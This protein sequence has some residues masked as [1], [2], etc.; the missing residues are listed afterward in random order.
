MWMVDV[1]HVCINVKWQTVTKWVRSSGI[2]GRKIGSTG[3]LRENFVTSLKRVSL[4]FILDMRFSYTH[5]SVK[6][7]AYFVY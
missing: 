7:G 3:V 6:E 5:R 2:F 1:P 4:L